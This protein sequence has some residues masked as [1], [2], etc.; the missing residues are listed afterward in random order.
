MA[1]AYNDPQKC[2]FLVIEPIFTPHTPINDWIR[3]IMSEIG[4]PNIWTR[5]LKKNRTLLMNLVHFYF[6]F[7]NYCCRGGHFWPNPR[8]FEAWK[9]ERTPLSSLDP[10]LVFCLGHGPRTE[11]PSWFFQSFSIC[12]RFKLISH[13]FA[14]FEPL[15][16]RRVTSRGHQESPWWANPYLP[17]MSQLKNS[18]QFR[19]P[20]FGL[21][22]TPQSDNHV[23][24][25]Y[26]AVSG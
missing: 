24:F 15:K 18:G 26:G 9:C 12:L 17:T 23:G 3:S 25:I 6:L 4:S 8:L 14:H 22:D 11:V 5:C 2:V 16:A 13:N 7:L 20:T 21:S 1:R 19:I 10:S